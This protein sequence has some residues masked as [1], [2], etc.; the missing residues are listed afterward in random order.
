MSGRDQRP[1]WEEFLISSSVLDALSDSSSPSFRPSTVDLPL[2][3]RLAAHR[4]KPYARGRG[5]LS[6]QTGLSRNSAVTLPPSPDVSSPFLIQPISLRPDTSQS[7]DGSA[8]LK[9]V[10]P[11]GAP[12]PQSW[13]LQHLLPPSSFSASPALA[14]I[15][16]PGRAALSVRPLG[17][18]SSLLSSVSPHRG[19]SSGQ[20]S[21]TPAA[22]PVQPWWDQHILSPS[23]FGSAPRA[24]RASLAPSTIPSSGPLSTAALSS[25]APRSS[26]VGPCHLPLQIA[27][28]AAT[29]IG[30]ASGLG[31]ATP[32]ATSASLL[33]SSAPS[34][35]RS[36]TS[37]VPYSRPAARPSP[38]ATAS[39]SPPLQGTFCHS[40]PWPGSS[41]ASLGAI[42]CRVQGASRS[43]VH[44]P[45]SP[46]RPSA[47]P[48]APAAPPGVAVLPLRDSNPRPH[49]AIS[50]APS[51]PFTVGTPSDTPSERYK[52]K[53]SKHANAC[54]G[55]WAASLRSMPPP[56][57][58]GR[59]RALAG[60]GDVPLPSAEVRS[61]SQERSA[62]ALVAILPHG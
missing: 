40:A 8:A 4:A 22:T 36:C 29:Q 1:F 46:L 27:T 11:H 25:P 5:P 21:T 43:R 50:V 37:I 18:S 23:A 47:V 3:R 33:S 24:S 51:V 31:S 35:P 42:A 59:K 58:T 12:T 20:L 55:P 10:T 9:Q 28:A 61:V 26:G 2:P 45:E 16:T 6:L 15:P 38:A 48:P 30:A 49:R 62:R 52:G 7:T 13:W 34:E 14:P 57:V 56:P 41:A 17:L 32:G 39:P 19:A 44:V 54:P 60:L 53:G